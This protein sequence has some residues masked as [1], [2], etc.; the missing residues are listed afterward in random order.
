MKNRS[1]FLLTTTSTAALFGVLIGAAL[2]P[3]PANAEKVGVAAAVNPDAFSSL[4]G[5]PQSQLNIGKSIFYNERINTTASGLVQVLLV[6][7]S[8]FTVGPGSDLVIDKFVYNPKKQTGQVV[9]S[10]SKGV[11]RYVGGKISK[12]DD[13]VTVKTPAGTLAIRGGMVQGTVNGN[14]GIF[15]FLYGVRMTFT[16]R[17]GQTYTV[18]QPG[19]TLDLTSGVPKVRPTTAADIKTVMSG[20]TNSNTSAILISQATGDRI[21]DEIASQETEEDLP[22]SPPPPPPRTD[23]TFNGYAA[24]WYKDG[25]LIDPEQDPVD[26]NLDDVEVGRLANLYPSRVSVT[27]NAEQNSVTGNFLVR[28][29]QR[30]LPLGF[31]RE[32]GARF[33]FGEPSTFGSD[34]DYFATANQVTINPFHN[35]SITTDDVEGSLTSGIGGPLCENCEFLR[36]GQ[37]TIGLTYE[38]EDNSDYQNGLTDG[39]NPNPDVTETRVAGTIGYW[40]AGDLPTYDEISLL[41][42][43]GTA[44]YDGTTYGTVIQKINGA[45]KP[46]PAPASG[47]IHMDWDF[48]YRTGEMVITKFKAPKVDGFQRPPRIDLTGTMSIPG[49]LDGASMNRFRGG[50]EGTVGNSPNNPIHGFASGSFARN[51]NDPVGG[52]VGNW[53]ASNHNLRANAIFG[54]GKVTPGGN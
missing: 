45:W 30:F 47:T 2:L 17:N 13:A 25:R 14:K 20:L 54:A 18:Y 19:Y 53:S 50:L 23:G 35:Q 26:E 42:L 6:D 27:F 7:G 21:T 38:A 46:Y 28:S 44:T 12:N 9:A 24:G 10:F 16:G 22:P 1:T 33:L 52:I 29:Y 11:M 40:V 32:G 3:L 39:E 43:Q 31:P 37:W 34:S 8:T 41:E 48:A 49:Q 15:S 5:A 4:S 36:W 51:G